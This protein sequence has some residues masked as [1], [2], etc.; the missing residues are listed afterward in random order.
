MA[1]KGKFKTTIKNS[2]FKV[3]PWF[4]VIDNFKTE[5]LLSI[6][7]AEKLQILQIKDEN[8]YGIISEN[9]GNVDI[10]IE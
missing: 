4:Y 2:D 9:F 6:N 8:I 10:I 7:T 1:L 3:C 5:N